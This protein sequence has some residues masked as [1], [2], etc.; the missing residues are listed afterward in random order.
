MSTSEYFKQRVSMELLG[1]TQQ[2]PWE[3]NEED[4]FQRLSELVAAGR[5]GPSEPLLDASSVQGPQ[6]TMH[7][8]LFDMHQTMRETADAA[9]RI[10]HEQGTPHAPAPIAAT[11][12]APAA[13]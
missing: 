4:L 2:P 6:G 8:L 9:R 7:R 3:I 1:D 5:R 11:A 13:A 12:T 10:V